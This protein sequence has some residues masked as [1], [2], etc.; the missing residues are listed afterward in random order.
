MSD[1]LLALSEALV[2][3]VD[4]AAQS[5]VAVHARPRLASTGVHWR[6][7]LIVTTD[8]TVRRTEGITVTL[9]DGRSIPATLKGRVEGKL[10]V[11]FK[12]G[13]KASGADTRVRA[14]A[15]ASNLSIEH[16]MGK[17]RLEAA[18]LQFS[19]DGKDLSAR[20]S[21]RM[22]GASSWATML[23]PEARSLSAK[24]RARPSP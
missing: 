14:L 20:G 19:I 7:G 5:I 15:N 13:P 11:D 6:D 17:E 23:P 3:A 21:G 4:R 12:V 16:L 9:P 22:F 2:G 24:A 18:S 10:T 1:T 8:G